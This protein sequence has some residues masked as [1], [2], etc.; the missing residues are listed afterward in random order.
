VVSQLDG[1]MIPEEEF[2][3]LIMTAE[4]CPD[5][6]TL[7]FTETLDR[8]ILVGFDSQD[9]I[10]P[11]KLSSITC[12]KN[13][14]ELSQVNAMKLKVQQRDYLDILRQSKGK[15]DV[16]SD[17]DDV[18]HD[19][20]AKMDISSQSKEEGDVISDVRDV[21]DVSHDVSAKSSA[22]TYAQ[23]TARFVPFQ[24]GGKKPAIEIRQSESTAKNIH[25]DNVE[26]LHVKNVNKTHVENVQQNQGELCSIN[27]VNERM[28]VGSKEHPVNKDQMTSLDVKTD[29]SGMEKRNRSNV[30]YAENH[31]QSLDERNRLNVK[32]VNNVN[33][34]SDKASQKDN[35][36]VLGQS[37]RNHINV[38][39][40]TRN[41]VNGISDETSQ[42]L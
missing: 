21:N 14:S 24:K 25:V 4:V 32:Y 38:M 22:I 35:T 42:N 1:K 33:G 2:V 9:N 40:A 13:P 30:K 29:V 28:L 19:V 8:K 20:S 34:T 10:N 31:S 39:Y 27:V 26:K 18:N 17:V 37:K 6:Q 16:I 23:V 41:N 3:N 11:E 5:F 15:S 7:I 12:D 36:D